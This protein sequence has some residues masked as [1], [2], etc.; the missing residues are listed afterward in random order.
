MVKSKLRPT[1]HAGRVVLQHT[2]KASLKIE[3]SG[4]RARRNP[5]GGCTAQGELGQAWKHE[6][7]L[8]FPSTGGERLSQTVLV[9]SCENPGNAAEAAPAGDAFCRTVVDRPT[10]PMVAFWLVCLPDRSCL[11]DRR[12]GLL[13]QASVM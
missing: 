6:G 8:Q 3:P 4:Q 13:F 12:D 10:R 2:M 5:A 1:T 11:I 9:H 7:L